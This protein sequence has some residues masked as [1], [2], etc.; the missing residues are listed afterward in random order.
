M[1][2]EPLEREPMNNEPL[3]R[4]PIDRVRVIAPGSIVDCRVLFGFEH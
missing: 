4:E 2:N 3:E 1:N